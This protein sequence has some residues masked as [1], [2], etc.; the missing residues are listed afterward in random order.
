MI[1]KQAEG[2]K[3]YRTEINEIQNWKSIHEINGTKDWLFEKINN[4]DKPIARLTK[5]KER[6]YKLLVSKMK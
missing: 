2:E 4:I 3:S 6:M 5:E 1:L